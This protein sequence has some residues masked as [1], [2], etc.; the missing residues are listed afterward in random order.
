[1]EQQRQGGRTAGAHPMRQHL[2]SLATAFTQFFHQ[3]SLGV[4]DRIPAARDGHLRQ[5]KS[6]ELLPGL[7]FA[8][9][10]RTLV[11]VQRFY[12]A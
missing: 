6:E 2:A 11:H 10:V 5:P 4:I 1:M 7:G 9:L 3:V 12:Q 8:A